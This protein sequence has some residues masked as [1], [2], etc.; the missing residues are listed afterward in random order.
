MFGTEFKER[1]M[2]VQAQAIFHGSVRSTSERIWTG[3]SALFLQSAAVKIAAIPDVLK[4]S[5]T[6]STQRSG[7]SG[8][9]NGILNILD[10]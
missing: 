4:E 3:T 8:S 5:R 1:R 2:W 9:S 10:I 6:L 7:D